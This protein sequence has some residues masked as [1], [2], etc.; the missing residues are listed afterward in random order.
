MSR[1]WIMGLQKL[2]S[3]LFPHIRFFHYFCKMK[4]EL[5]HPRLQS[6]PHRI[7]LINSKETPQC[8]V[9]TKTH[10]IGK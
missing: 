4:R 3:A 6:P 1:E 7:K 9:S 2:Y 5:G 8:D 10:K